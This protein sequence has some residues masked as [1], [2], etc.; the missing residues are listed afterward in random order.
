MGSVLERRFERI[1]R[2]EGEAREAHLV[3]V[4]IIGRHRCEQSIEHTT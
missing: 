2:N 3:G 4:L 1:R